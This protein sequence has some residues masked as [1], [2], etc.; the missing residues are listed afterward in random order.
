MRVK[1]V[2][3]LFQFSAKFEMVIDFPVKGNRCIAIIRDD[4]LVSALQIDNF[5]A[6]RAHREKARTVD[7]ALIRAAMRQRRGGLFDSLGLRRP[8]FVCKSRNPA[9]V[10]EPLVHRQIEPA[11]QSPLQVPPS[12]ENSAVAGYLA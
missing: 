9:Q 12:L 4:G 8:I 7:S 6:C 11:S 3:E 2:P 1:P 5:Q 10:R